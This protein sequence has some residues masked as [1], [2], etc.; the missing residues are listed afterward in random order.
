MNTNITFCQVLLVLFQSNRCSCHRYSQ[1]NKSLMKPDRKRDFLT[2]FF[3]A[4]MIS[5]LSASLQGGFN[6]ISR[7]GIT[8]SSKR[9]KSR[10][11]CVLAV[12]MLWS[13]YLCPRTVYLGVPLLAV[14]THLDT[15]T[16]E[17]TRPH[18]DVEHRA[19]S[20]VV[21]GKVEHH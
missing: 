15:L 16:E 1:E 6:R 10:I 17:E 11:R 4:I 21:Q 19:L 3:V 13:T 5:V 8:K 20:L 9:L 12:R 7:S 2:H 18:D 14:Q